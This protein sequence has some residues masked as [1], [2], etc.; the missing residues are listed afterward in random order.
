MTG[1][2]R[3]KGV[4]LPS[5]RIDEVTWSEAAAE[6]VRSRP[7]RQTGQ[8]TLEPEWCTEAALDPRRVVRVAGSANPATASLKVVGFSPSAFGRG[9]LLKVWLW[10]DDPLDETWNGGSGAPANDSD[11]RAY[12]KGVQ[13][14]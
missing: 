3:Y 14:E 11:R 1:R 8:P 9:D 2:P 6:H 10:S 7:E 5:L 13:N 4:D 12:A